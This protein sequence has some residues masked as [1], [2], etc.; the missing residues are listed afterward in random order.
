[1]ILHTNP[2]IYESG[3]PMCEGLTRH[4]FVVLYH[5]NSTM[6]SL[7]HHVEQPHLWATR[8][9][10]KKN[11]VV[12][13]V[14]SGS[15]MQIAS[16]IWRWRRFWTSCTNKWIRYSF[17]YCEGMAMAMNCTASTTC[18][19]NVSVPGLKYFYVDS[20]S[21]CKFFWGDC[22]LALQNSWLQVAFRKE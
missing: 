19:G 5:C 21:Y 13:R 20:I 8:V 14:W 15:L 9:G 11:Y 16:H 1:M 2:R 3:G 4:Y 10:K 7:F 12:L 18:K 22:L 6:T 17:N